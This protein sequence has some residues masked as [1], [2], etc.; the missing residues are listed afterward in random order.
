MEHVSTLCALGTVGVAATGLG[1]GRVEGP[2]KPELHRRSIFSSYD[3][4]APA[5]PFADLQTFSDARPGSRHL[6]SKRYDV[7]PHSEAFSR[8]SDSFD[9][10]NSEGDA[11]LRKEAIL[12]PARLRRRRQTYT[13]PP[14]TQTAEDDSVASHARRPS[15]SW[16]RRLSGVSHLTE[17]V[18]S[19]RPTTASFDG[20]TA[21]ILNES[22]G[23]RREPNKLV[24][25]TIS[26]HG[27]GKS[28]FHR[29]SLSI[30]AA[31]IL[32]RPATSYQRSESLKFPDLVGAPSDDTNL[33]PAVALVSGGSWLPYFRSS[34]DGLRDKAMRRFSTATKPKDQPIRRILPTNNVAPTLLLATSISRQE[35]NGDHKWDQASGTP[36]QFRDPFSSTISVPKLKDPPFSKVTSKLEHSSDT[37]NKGSPQERVDMNGGVDSGLQNDTL[38]HAKGRALSTPVPEVTKLERTALG[39]PRVQRRRN[40]TDPNVFRRPQNASAPG[41]SISL[42]PKIRNSSGSYGSALSPQNLRDGMIPGSDAFQ[43]PS[44]ADAL[45]VSPTSRP[46]ELRPS[47]PARQR[48]TR[49]SS[50][51]ISNP[52][53]TVIGSDDTRVFTSGDEDESDFLSDTA[54]DSVRTRVTLNSVSDICSPRIEGLFD[55]NQ[56]QSVVVG[57]GGLSGL[58]DVLPPTTFSFPETNQEPDQISIL[59]TAHKSSLSEADRSSHMF[60]NKGPMT[61]S[62]SLSSDDQDACSLVG[63]LPSELNAQFGRRLAVFPDDEDDFGASW[64]ANLSVFSTK[65]D[66]H[67]THPDS[68]SLNDTYP[69]MNPFDWSEDPRNERETE[70]TEV[71]PRTVHGKQGGG[72]LRGS[73]P[74]ARKGAHTLHLRSQSVPV[75]RE[76]ALSNDSRQPPGKF[77]TWGLGSK[78]V[79]EDWDSDFEFEDADNSMIS[80]SNK[81]ITTKVGGSRGMFVPQAIMERQASLHGQFGHVQ[82]LTLLVEEM[83]RLR[84]QA[85]LLQIAKGPSSELWREAEGIVNLATVDDEEHYPSPP[86]SPSSLTF[87]FNDS[88]EE[89]H[90]RPNSADRNS[91]ESWQTPPSEHT[92]SNSPINSPD[93]LVKDLPARPKSVLD[94][95][96]QQRP[97]CEPLHLDVKGPP[98]QKVAFD[99]QSLRDLVVRAGVVTRALKDV[100][101]KAEGVTSTSDEPLP[102]SNPPFSRIFD[103]PPTVFSNY[104]AGYVN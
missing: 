64:D 59:D 72:D 5:T 66:T 101:R 55:R 29:S 30:T 60:D 34:L 90:P 46:F 41:L 97:A 88:E 20:S 45:P 93:R 82:E 22:S 16:L 54:F 65:T 31:P 50:I 10:P 58:P 81:D 2:S 53:S 76:P 49:L 7:S 102:T 21:P 71:R 61:S 33:S 94:M 74:P 86:R 92:G 42:P 35:A 67:T 38:T 103:Q 37:N 62:I 51:A 69:K 11:N 75:A 32:R 17:S 18:S 73:R 6:G 56:G 47:P 23:Q 68:R 12:G 100:I 104:E 28:L 77:G 98:P 99:T 1:F 3:R 43:R 63:A 85:S 87:S 48:T 83:K 14:V 36:V 52:S 4:S 39:G 79:S 80:D 57:H 89:A 8:G 95:I 24:K 40:I 91:G 26:Q 19:P 9:T 96:Y 44:T 25:R 27:N 15:S 84:H 13:N 78:G 70:G